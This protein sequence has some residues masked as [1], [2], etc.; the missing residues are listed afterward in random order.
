MTKKEQELFLTEQ[1]AGGCPEEKLVGMRRHLRSICEYL[2]PDKALTKKKLKR[3]RQ[4]LLDRG[5]SVRTIETAATSAWRTPFVP[6]K[7]GQGRCRASPGPAKCPGT[8]GM[9]LACKNRFRDRLKTRRMLKFFRGYSD[10]SAREYGLPPSPSV[11]PPSE[12]E[13]LAK[14][15]RPFIIANGPLFEGAVTK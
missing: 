11:T 14:L 1:Q 9:S 2:P 8:G 5:L 12:R 7:L 6:G 10:N 13:A 4:A 15:V 3:W